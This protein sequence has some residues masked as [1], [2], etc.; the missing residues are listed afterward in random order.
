V[1]AAGA[2]YTALFAVLLWQALHGHSLVASDAAALVPLGLWAASTAL[3]FGVIAGARHD[4][5]TEVVA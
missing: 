1:L 4:G 3:A 5:P 2:S